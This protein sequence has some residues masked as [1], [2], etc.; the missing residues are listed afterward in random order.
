MLSCQGTSGTLLASTLLEKAKSIGSGEPI[1]EVTRINLIVCIYSCVYRSK[2]L[3]AGD[4]VFSP[5]TFPPNNDVAVP[6]SPTKIPDLRA[7]DQQ[8]V[9]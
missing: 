6:S 5:A 3:N 4:K 2:P 8:E 7:E 9:R 1:A